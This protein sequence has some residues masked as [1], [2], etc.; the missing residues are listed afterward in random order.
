MAPL[1][2]SSDTS[3]STVSNN[4]VTVEPSNPLYLDP[5]DNPG[6][7]II[8]VQF[9]SMGY[10]SWRRG[11][12]IVITWILNSLEAEIR[13]SV[14]YTESATKLWKDIEKRYGQP[15]RSKVCIRF[16]RLSHLFLKGL[17]TLLPTF[18]ELRSCGMS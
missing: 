13:E 15:N 6:T 8:V 1:E 14:M 16:V 3:T 10:E 18:P 5:T 2:T 9:N 12:L 17:R 4:S 11:M 7:I